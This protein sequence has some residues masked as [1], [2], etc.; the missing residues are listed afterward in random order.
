MH[1]EKFDLQAVQFGGYW[2]VAGLWFDL[3]DW[4]NFLCCDRVYRHM[5]VEPGL[6]G[7][8]ELI[9]PNGVPLELFVGH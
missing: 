9:D 1:K 5:T 3:Y 7:R 2:R 4:M 6:H 8:H